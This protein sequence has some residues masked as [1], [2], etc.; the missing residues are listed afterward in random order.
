MIKTDTR[1]LYNDWRNMMKKL[2]SIAMV[3][4]MIFALFGCSSD[5]QSYAGLNAEIVAIN[6]ELNGFTIKSLDDD[7]ILGEKCYINLESDDV[8][9]IYVD[10]ETEELQDLQ[11]SDF[12]VGDVIT[13]DVDTN[14]IQNRSVVPKQIQLSTQRI[15]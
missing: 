10:Y 12:V 1:N 9:Y 7:S 3:F 11:Y 4:G 5:V 13:I 14:G 15:K 2:L 8:N 6:S